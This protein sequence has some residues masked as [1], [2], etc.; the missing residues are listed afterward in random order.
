METMKATRQAYGEALVELA[1]ADQRIVVVDADLAHA[2]QTIIFK[3][4]F[5]QRHYNIGIAE[6]N[7]V[8]MAAGMS[9]TGLVPFCSTFAIFGTGRVYE[10]IRNSIAYPY[11][12]VKLAMTHAGISVG[13]DGGSHQ[14]IEDIALMRVIPGMTVLCPVDANETRAAVYAA[15]K[16]DGPV[17]LR[18]SRQATAIMEG[19]LNKPFQIGTAN[20]LRDGADVA[21]FAYGLMVYE[22]LKAADILAVQ[23]VRASVINM[24]TIKPLDTQCISDCAKRC[25]HIAVAEEHSVI[26]G[27]G[28]AVASV[29]A[30]ES[31]S[32]RFTKIGI[33]DRF[34][35]S[36]KPEEL[37]QEYGL[38]GKQ[39]AERIL[40]EHNG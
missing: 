11:F 19:A 13:E 15:T 38:T 35:Q 30:Q 1:A 10:Q 5:P 25:S 2:T 33:E 14:S 28:D 24:H 40:C 18:L 23:G 3:E 21:I 32:V 27:L 37:F 9:T 26:G 22:A 6:S 7:M 29:L 36:G 31:I 34:G 12:N 20:I 8:T 16:L 17:Y 4:A 39:V